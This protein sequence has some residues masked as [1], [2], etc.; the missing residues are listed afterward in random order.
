[1]VAAG[2]VHASDYRQQAA[3]QDLGTPVAATLASTIACPACGTGVY[4]YACTGCKT[5]LQ[6]LAG[7]C[8]AFCSF[9]DVKCPPIQLARSCCSSRKP[10]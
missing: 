10:N 9:G 7:D 2:S 8:C 4:F 1:M 3:H 6:P 5:L